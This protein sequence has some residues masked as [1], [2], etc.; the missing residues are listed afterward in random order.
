MTVGLSEGRMACRP[1]A[2][3]P[4]TRGSVA[5]RPLGRRLVEASTGDA[6]RRG[7]ATCGPAAGRP[8]DDEPLDLCQRLG[9]RS[10]IV[11]RPGV[12]ADWAL[13]GNAR[14][15]LGPGSFADDDHELATERQAAAPRS[16]R[17]VAERAP[18]DLL[19]ELRQLAADRGRPI[20][21]AGRREVAERRWDPG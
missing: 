15:R 2:V 20:R 10:G 3:G 16:T 21:A 12:A 18:P 13:G 14:R 1:G 7:N 9:E 17:Q 11:A 19:V 5:A 6:G 8:R 4:E